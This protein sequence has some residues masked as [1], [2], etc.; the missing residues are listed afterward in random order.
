MSLEHH[1]EGQ[2]LIARYTGERIDASNA[3]EFR[4]SMNTLIEQHDQIVID[5]T[6]VRFIDSAGVG[7]LIGCLRAISDRN[8]KLCLAGLKGPVQALFDLMR[9]HRVFE[10]HTDVSSARTAMQ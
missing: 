9:L 1:L 10:I 8:G 6:G 4:Q 5:L 3:A 2:C 7:S